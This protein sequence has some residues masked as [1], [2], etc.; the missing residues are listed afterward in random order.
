M[1][2]EEEQRGRKIR[3]DRIMRRGKYPDLRRK[4]GP[5]PCKGI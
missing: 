2:L 3:R 4:A 1:G 5:I